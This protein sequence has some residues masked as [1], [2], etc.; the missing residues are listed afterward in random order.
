[1]N[2]ENSNSK[3]IPEKP[4]PSCEGQLSDIP[5]W[6]KDNEYVKSGYR[7]NYS[8][9]KEIAWSFF[10]FHNET[11]NIWS[12][13]LGKVIFFTIGVL[14]FINYPN[15]Q[16]MG[17]KGMAEYNKLSQDMTIEKFANEKIMILQENVK[18]ANMTV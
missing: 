3:P 5:V 16:A 12:H 8:S 4:G 2:C 9:N 11:V 17:Q 10:Q 15:M 14:L 1:L 7:V 13:F 18:L 6:N